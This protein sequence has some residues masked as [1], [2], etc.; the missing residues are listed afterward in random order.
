MITT[1]TDRAALAERVLAAV[2]A[3]IR[4]CPA[5]TARRCFSGFPQAIEAAYAEMW[6]ANMDYVQAAP[7]PEETSIDRDARA[8]FSQHSRRP[9]HMV[10]TN[11][12]HGDGHPSAVL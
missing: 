1:T 12:H 11:D 4:A 5:M 8:A 6:D 10:D 7:L 2:D 9:A 3:F